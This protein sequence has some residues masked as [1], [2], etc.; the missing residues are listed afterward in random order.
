MAE[1]K[2]SSVLVQLYN[3]PTL[4]PKVDRALAEKALTYDEIVEMC[5]E[6]GL[7]ISKSSLSRYKDKME[8]AFVTG[9]DPEELLDRR[10]DNTLVKLA[11]K[12]MAGTTSNSVKTNWGE[13][14]NRGTKIY[15]YLEVLDDMIEKGAN[16]LDLIDALEPSYLLKAIELRNKIDGGQTQGLTNIGLTE[17][18][19]RYQ[20]RI[21]ALAEVV[22]EFIPEERHEEVLAAISTYEEEYYRDM[23][24][25][26]EEKRMEKFI[27]EEYD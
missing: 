27:D 7:T 21:N 8:E 2:S 9:V 15:S 11:D 20:A 22:M 13:V 24:L 17:L 25:G 1:K 4:K 3:H 19:A 12:E 16:G 14:T 5:A 6:N 26:D 23:D 10:V 18:S